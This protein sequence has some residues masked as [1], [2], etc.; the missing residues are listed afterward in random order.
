MTYE[1]QSARDREWEKNRQR[2][3]KA[4]EERQD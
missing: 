4:E 1:R 2:D 3:T